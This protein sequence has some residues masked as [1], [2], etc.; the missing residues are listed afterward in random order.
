M[1]LVSVLVGAMLAL[2]ACAG[3]AGLGG[4]PAKP[5][6]RRRGLRGPSDLLATH[7]AVLDITVPEPGPAELRWPDGSTRPVASLGGLPF[8]RVLSTEDGRTLTISFN[9]VF[10][11]ADTPCGADYWVVRE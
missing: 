11:G 7:P 8:D 4:P 9:G 2:A 3:G 5:I 6:R 10:G 1:R